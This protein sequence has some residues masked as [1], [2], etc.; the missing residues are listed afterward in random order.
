MIADLVVFGCFALRPLTLKGDGE[1]SWVPGESLW[2]LPR[3]RDPATP[4][5]SRNIGRPDAAFRLV[6]GVGIATSRFSELNLHGLLPRYVRFAPPSHPVNGNTRYRL[7][8][9]IEHVKEHHHAEG[10]KRINE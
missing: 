4:A 7:L 8:R 6:N 10:T 1:L 5:R 2:K 9:S 3:A